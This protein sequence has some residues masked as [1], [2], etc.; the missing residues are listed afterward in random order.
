MRA[1]CEEIFAARDTH[2]WPPDLDIPGHWDEPY[3]RLA[4]D[5]RFPLTEVHDAAAKVRGLI[6]SID[7]SP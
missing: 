7:A 6:T 2:A 5:L 1:A 4:T 3:M